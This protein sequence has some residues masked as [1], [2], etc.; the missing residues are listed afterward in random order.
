MN[1]APALWVALRTCRTLLSPAPAPGLVIRNKRLR[2][3]GGLSYLECPSLAQVSAW[4]LQLS[5]E[6]RHHLYKGVPSERLFPRSSPLSDWVTQPTSST[7]QTRLCIPHPTLDTNGRSSFPS[8]AGTQGTKC[9]SQRR[10]PRI[11][12]PECPPWELRK[13]RTR[14]PHHKM[15]LLMELRI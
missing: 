13:G 10:A 12:T 6:S 4:V 14:C 1:A 9:D 3:D 7:P 8:R 15:A 11:K 2:L 5:D